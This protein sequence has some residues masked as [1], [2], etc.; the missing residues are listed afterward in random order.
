[1]DAAKRLGFDTVLIDT[2]GRLHIDD[3]LMDELTA[4]RDAV[5]P[6][7]ILFVADAMTGQ[8][9]VR[10][11][12]EFHHRIG[13]TGI[14]LSK[15]D[16][17]ARGGA[18]LSVVSVVNVPVAFA[19]TGET[20]DDLEPFRPDRM[21]SRLLGMGD[22]LSLV[23]KAEQAIARDDAVAMA[24]RVRR[25]EFTLEDLREQLRMVS[26]MGPLDQLLGM[27][28]GLG[29]AAA[30]VELGDGALT[31]T[32]AII[33]SMTPGERAQPIGDERQ[34]A[35]PDRAGQRNERA[36]S[37]PALA[38]VHE[39]AE[40]DEGGGGRGAW[41]ETLCPPAGAPVVSRAMARAGERTRC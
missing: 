33:N 34:P 24:E 3:A 20:L 9:A 27:I 11:A 28:P 36:G 40:D 26:R 23:E 7:D 37:E 19:A 25:N 4:I 12:G 5:S 1:M 13:V 31:R 22:V 29:N 2:A 41:Q 10:S 30:G 14:V 38:A 39:D 16:G 32:T 8:D 15:M 6:S 21:V 17:D 35:A 18:A